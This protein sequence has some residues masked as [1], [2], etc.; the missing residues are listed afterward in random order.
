MKT[1]RDDMTSLNNS[2]ETVSNHTSHLNNGQ[3]EVKV[4]LASLNSSLHNENQQFRNRLDEQKRDMNSLNSFLQNH[5]NQLSNRLDELKGDWTSLNDSL[6]TISNH[7]SQLNNR[8]EAVNESLTHRQLQIAAELAY[9]QTSLSH[10]HSQEANHTLDSLNKKLEAL[11]ASISQQKVLEENKLTNL[12]TSL[13]FAS[14]KLNSLINTT[15]QLSDQQEIRANYNLSDVECM[16]TEQSILLHQTL[17]DNLTHQ[18]ETIQGYLESCGDLNSNTTTTTNKSTNY[19][20]TTPLP[21]GPYTCGGTGGWRRAV[22]MNMT[23]PNTTCPSG[24]QETTY[25]KRTCGKVSN[26]SLSCDSV[27]FPVNGGPYNRVC[28]RIIGYQYNVID[29]F[30]SY[31]D[32]LVTTIDEAYVSGVSLTHGSPRQHIWTFAAGIAE[33]RPT[34]KDACPCDATINITVP[35]FVGGDYFCE[36]GVNSGDPSGFHPE[37]PLWDGQNCRSS[38]SCCSFRDPPYFVRDLPSPTTDDLEARL[39]W[40]NSVD[41]SP[42]ELIELYVQ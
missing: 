27:I 41:E 29:A 9:L 21:T 15:A 35:N 22:Y 18:M 8:L 2:F 13:N 1:I 3:D 28:G 5:T 7:T 11:N 17:Q 30:Q 32:G 40:L 26:G 16:N 4:D 36:S 23:D 25:S 34:R 31:H 37:D 42:I 20:T 19:N 14:S 6:Q 24:W 10:T 38:S 33:D 12:Q 39:C